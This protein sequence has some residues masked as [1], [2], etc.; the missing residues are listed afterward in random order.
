MAVLHAGE[1][2]GGESDGTQPPS[3]RSNSNVNMTDSEV[4]WP[5]ENQRRNDVRRIVTEVAEE[6]LDKRSTSN[7]THSPKPSV[8]NV[9]QLSR[10]RTE[11]SHTWGGKGSSAVIDKRR[12]NPPK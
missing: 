4:D 5:V 3:S 11:L 7:S 8:P 6:P 2:D 12:R 10:E 1:L 9:N